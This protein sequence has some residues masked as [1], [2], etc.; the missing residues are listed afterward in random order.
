MATKKKKLFRVFVY[1]TLRLGNHNHRWLNGA[2]LVAETQTAKA[3]F[4]MLDVSGHF[5]GVIHGGKTTIVG[6]VYAVDSETLAELD[7]HEGCPNH[8]R[9][10]IVRTKDCGECFT[11]IYQMPSRAR[12]YPNAIVNSGDWVEHRGYTDPSYADAIPEMQGA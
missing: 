10:E 4:T 7:R 2:K 6:E 1:G 9:R 11:Y 5:P 3:A 8:Y 12:A